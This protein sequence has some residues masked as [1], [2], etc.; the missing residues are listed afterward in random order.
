[1]K[2]IIS[3]ERAPAPVGPYS[4]VVAF[5]KLLF[6]S[7]Q[8]PLDTEAKELVI[9]MPARSKVLSCFVKRRTSVSFTLAPICMIESTEE[10]PPLSLLALEIFEGI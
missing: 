2:K 1:M 5:D 8:G 4:S 10:P 7:G 9:D 3:T 6:I